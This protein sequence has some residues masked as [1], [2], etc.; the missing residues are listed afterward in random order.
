MKLIEGFLWFMACAAV[1]FILRGDLANAAQW[2]IVSFNDAEHLAALQDSVVGVCDTTW[3]ISD[4]GIAGYSQ[5]YF[6]ADLQD[7][8]SG[9]RHFIKTVITCRELVCVAI[10]THRTVK[11]IRNPRTGESMEVTVKPGEA[12]IFYEEVRQ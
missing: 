5:Y 10:E 3:D 2:E 1:M 9:D 6:H 11:T 12:L 8:S 7:S 4:T